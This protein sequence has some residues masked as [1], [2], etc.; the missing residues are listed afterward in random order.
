MNL[1]GKSFPLFEIWKNV[2]KSSYTQSY[3]HYPHGKACG[4]VDLHNEERNKCFGYCYENWFFDKKREKC[5]DFFEI[6]I[7]LNIHGKYHNSGRKRK[8]IWQKEHGERGSIQMSPTASSQ[9]IVV[10]QLNKK[11]C[12][13]LKCFYLF[14]NPV[15]ILLRAMQNLPD[16]LIRIPSQQEPENPGVNNRLVC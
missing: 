8:I 4:W 1:C 14:F 10:R 2:E 15:H 6:K 12:A 11:M 9:F 7:L 13:S 16:F 5:I 3:P